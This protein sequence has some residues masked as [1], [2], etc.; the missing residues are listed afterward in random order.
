VTWLENARHE[1]IVLLDNDSTYAPLLDYLDETPHEV[2]RLGENLG[3]RALWLADLVPDE[4]FIYTDPDLIPTDECPLDAVEHLHDL[5]RR[6]P[7]FPKVALGLHLNDVPADR[8]SLEWER[9]L[10]APDRQI[11]PG[12]YNSLADT[13]FA[14]YQPGAAFS[15]TAIRCG[16][17]YECRHMPWYVT[18]PDAE[19]SYYLERAIVGPDGSSWAQGQQ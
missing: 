10:V 17:P 12:V 6:F 3:A 7:Q 13:T 14:L 19:D 2:I 18:E 15:L 16:K 9:S 11:A 1:R 5:R 8:P 4:P